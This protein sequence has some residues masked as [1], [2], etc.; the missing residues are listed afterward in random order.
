MASVPRTRC[1]TSLYLLGQPIESI[2]GNK[3]PSNGDV[4][5]RLFYLL[6][7]KNTLKVAGKIVYDEILL[8]WQK[9]RIPTKFERNILPKIND[10]Y[11]YLR[12]LQKN[13][14]RQ[15]ELQ[16]EKEATFINS[17]DDLFDIA[18]T[19]ALEIMSI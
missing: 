14:L 16:I 12:S 11:D 3:L 18:H 8:F 7:A 6:K 2:S 17:L 1:D 10:L 5:R 4:L 15:N 13:K 19:N 9:A